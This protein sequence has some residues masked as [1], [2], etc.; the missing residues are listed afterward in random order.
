[1]N[2]HYEKDADSS[3]VQ[4]RT[5]GVVGYGSQ[6]HAHG[7]NL[8]ESGVEAVAGLRS[9]SGSA[10]KAQVAGL[11]VASVA[12][13]AAGSDIVMMPAP[14][15]HPA[16]IYA[17]RVAGHA[18]GGAALAFARGFDHDPAAGS[19]YL[20]RFSREPDRLSSRGA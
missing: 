11:E 3:V 6:G 16:R 17:E 1:M 15:D 2:N 13:A 9:G 5:V 7:N 4:G 18:C 8:R 14:G 20:Y 19:G 12:E 10:A